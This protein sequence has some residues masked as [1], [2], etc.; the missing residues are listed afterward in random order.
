MR[1]ELKV[2]FDG[3]V[4]IASGHAVEGSE[5]AVQYDFFS[6]DHVDRA[7]DTL[8]RDYCRSFLHGLRI[9]ESGGY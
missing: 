8:Y 1:K 2:P 4:K 6:A 5:V 7:L 9:D 3:L